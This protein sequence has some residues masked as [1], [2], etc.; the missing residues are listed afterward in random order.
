MAPADLSRPRGPFLSVM[1]MPDFEGPPPVAAA[2]GD[3]SQRGRQVAGGELGLV[4]GIVAS[5]AGPSKCWLWAR[6]RASKPARSNGFDGP[7]LAPEA[8]FIREGTDRPS[9]GCKWRPRAT[10]FLFSAPSRP[11]PDGRTSGELSTELSDS[12]RAARIRRARINQLI[13]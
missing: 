10:R 7:A 9:E 4:C 8:K 6:P 12:Q 1:T 11:A 2:I 3:S 5:P 13:I